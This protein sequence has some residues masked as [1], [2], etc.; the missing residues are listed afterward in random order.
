MNQDMQ[1]RLKAVDAKTLELRRDAASV[2]KKAASS[3]EEFAHD[4]EGASQ[5][6]HAKA[7][8]KKADP[9]VAP[10]RPAASWPTWKYVL[11]LLGMAGLA[12]GLIV[13]DRPTH[14][15][16]SQDAAKVALAAPH[17]PMTPR[18]LAAGA[19]VVGLKAL[20]YTLF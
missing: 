11:T 12:A 19:G 14:Q 16:A 4:M 7:A 6:T 5:E 20:L 1:E 8:S 3:L 18:K 17:A 2:L 10:V 13:L 9:S 15:A